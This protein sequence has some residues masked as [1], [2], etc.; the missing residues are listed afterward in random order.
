MFDEDY[1]EDGLCIE[2]GEGEGQHDRCCTIGVE[3][4]V[5]LWELMAYGDDE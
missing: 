4:E 3:E 2:C 1:T 5:R